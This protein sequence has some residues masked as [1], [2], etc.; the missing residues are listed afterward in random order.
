MLQSPPQSTPG[1]ESICEFEGRWYVAHTKSRFEKQLALDLARLRIN[2][3]LPMK[4]KTYISGGKK[5]RSILPLFTS[6]LFFCSP[7]QEAKTEVF[8]T[9]RVATIID[10]A[11]RERFVT[12]LCAIEK[13]LKSNISLKLTEILPVGQRCR[14]NSG[15]ML[16]TE[17]VVL[18]C[19]EGKSRVVMEV[20]VLGKGVEMEIDSA[21]LEKV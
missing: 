19:L 14:I 17:G 12:E 7:V 5:R 18:Q 20:S 2:Y 16:G 13:A 15:A 10:V 3:F 1:F 11:D 21:M 8:R 6:Y 9:G 4:E